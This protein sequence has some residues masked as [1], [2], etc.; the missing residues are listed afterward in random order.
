[1]AWLAL[2]DY[3]PHRQSAPNQ[4]WDGRPNSV[5]PVPPCHSRE[6]GNPSSLRVAR[7][8]L[9]LTVGRVSL[10]L[11]TRHHALRVILQR[12]KLY[13]SLGQNGGSHEFAGANRQDPPQHT[14]E[15]CSTHPK[16]MG[17]PCHAE[18]SRGVSGELSNLGTAGPR[19][20][21][22]EK[23][24]PPYRSLLMCR[25]FV[26]QIVCNNFKTVDCM[27]PPSSPGH[28]RQSLCTTRPDHQALKVS[29]MIL[30]VD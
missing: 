6:G 17:H 26:V 13:L 24:D 21:S 2:F 1:V 3:A 14:R 15:A 23:K 10:L 18:R 25:I 29:R 5:I 30:S 11:E 16:L 12:Q 20:G 4:G 22:Q 9:L 7:N 8:S 28:G 19:R 27:S